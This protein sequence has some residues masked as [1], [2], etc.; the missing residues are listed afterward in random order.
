M[1]FE[2]SPM[3]LIAEIKAHLGVLYEHVRQDDVADFYLSIQELAAQVQQV[4]E[5]DE[6]LAISTILL[7]SGADY[8]TNHSVDSAIVCELVAQSFDYTPTQRCSLIAAALS[9]NIGM[10]DLQSR[11]YAHHGLI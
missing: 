4:C 6:S 3:D 5:Q 11:L 7:K 2:T 10:L 9:M 8:L 1:G